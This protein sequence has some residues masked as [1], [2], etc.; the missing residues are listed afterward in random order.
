MES[1][2][3]DWVEGA[4]AAYSTSQGGY[5]AMTAPGSF[6]KSAAD[7]TTL[8][9]VPGS[10]PKIV[11]GWCALQGGAGSPIA[12]ASA[13]ASGSKS[14]E[15]VVV[16]GLGTKSYGG[17]GSGKLRAFDGD[18]GALLAEGSTLMPDLEHWISPIVALGR[19]YVAGD[20]HVY[21]FDLKGAAHKVTPPG[22]AGTGDGGPP[23]SC[24]LTISP[25][26]VDPCVPF[27]LTCQ[28][29]PDESE[30]GACAAPTSDQACL[31]TVP[32]ASGLACVNRG[33]KNVCEQTCA[34]TSD[35]P[36]LFDEC[37]PLD[38]GTLTCNSVACGPGKDGGTGFYAACASGTGTCVPVYQGDGS[39]T[40]LCMASGSSTGD[41]S[42]GAACGASRGA[43]P[44]CPVGSFC[45]T[46]SSTSACL[47]LCD[48]TGATFGV[49][50]GGPACAA[51]QT[52]I[53]LG[54]DLPA[55]ACAQTCG[56]DAGTDCPPGLSCQTWNVLTNQSACLP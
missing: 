26:Q 40:G 7:L 45:F 56:G 32:C 31:P 54:G 6:C 12:S 42:A 4:M 38:G 28:G 23:G 34:L 19:V 55:G 21:A 50:A 33:G 24:L 10:P 51:G 48:Y 5:V 29:N 15:D 43:G 41:A 49:D 27:G 47:S 52:C 30:L 2:T 39:Q 37:A 13:A 11:A 14:A 35:C 16:W 8:K 18:T 36:S 53:I 44:L 17:A 1:A 9:I 20:S 46:G 25:L 22:D 3:A